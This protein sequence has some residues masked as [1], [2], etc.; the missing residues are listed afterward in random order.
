VRCAFVR[1]STRNDFTS[2]HLPLFHYNIFLERLGTQDHIMKSRAVLGAFAWAQLALA[3]PIPAIFVQGLRSE[4]APIAGQDSGSTPAIVDAELKSTSDSKATGNSIDN[5]PQTTTSDSSPAAVLSSAKPVETTYLLSLSALKSAAQATSPSDADAESFVVIQ[6]SE[7]GIRLRSDSD[8]ITRNA[9]VFANPDSIVQVHIG[10][11]DAEGREEDEHPWHHRGHGRRRHH[12][13]HRKT[14]WRHRHGRHRG[15][16]ATSRLAKEY[17]DL[18]VI[19]L[20]L[21]FLL[22]VVAWET[23]ATLRNRYVTS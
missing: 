10:V 15:E 20:V 12:G 3:A 8:T 9:A 21:T 4:A 5:R 2:I 14:H 7:S 23:L 19:S 11:S 16:C 1:P 6:K 22:V 13:H 17:H 18:L